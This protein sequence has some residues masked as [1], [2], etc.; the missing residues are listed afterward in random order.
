[1]NNDILAEDLS[2][3]LKMKNRNN[4]F[5]LTEILKSK[6]QAFQALKTTSHFDQNEVERR[7]LQNR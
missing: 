3:A 4:F 7:N 1:M 2:A 5:S 6:L